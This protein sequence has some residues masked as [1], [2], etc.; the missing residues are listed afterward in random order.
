LTECHQLIVL[1]FIFLVF[2]KIN[3]YVKG[4]SRYNST[5]SHI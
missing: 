5:F 3:M 1:L 4:I 2:W